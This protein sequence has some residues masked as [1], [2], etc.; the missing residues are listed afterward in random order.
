MLAQHEHW[1]WNTFSVQDGLVNS[2]GQCIV[3]DSLGFIWIGTDEG[4][5]RFDGTYFMNFKTVGGDST[6]LIDNRI[7]YLAVEPGGNVLIGTVSGFSM[8]NYNTG[9]FYSHGFDNS[10]KGEEWN[11]IIR[12][13]HCWPDGHIWIFTRCNVYDWDRADNTFSLLDKSFRST[14]NG[15]GPVTLPTDDP[16]KCWV[17]APNGLAMVDYK[18][19]SIAKIQP[20]GD[21]FEPS[22]TVAN[23][24][25]CTMDKY[26]KIWYNSISHGTFYCYDPKTNYQRSFVQD[27][28][29]RGSR[30]PLSTMV[31]Y[32]DRNDRLWV[33]TWSAEAYVLDTILNQRRHFQINRHLGNGALQIVR[34][35]YQAKNGDFWVTGNFG[36]AVHSEAMESV[37]TETLPKMQGAILPHDQLLH[38][39]LADST[40]GSFY[41]GSA[42][43]LFYYDDDVGQFSFY[44]YSNKD[45]HGAITEMIW[46]GQDILCAT[47][48]GLYLFLPKSGKFKKWKSGIELLDNSWITD[49]SVIGDDMFI[50]TRKAE[51]Y[52]YK[53]SS[54]QSVLYKHSEF[55]ANSPLPSYYVKILPD[56]H[57]N[58]WLASN[59]GFSC[60]DLEDDI[61]THFKPSQND[62]LK[63]AGNFW[64]MVCDDDGYIWFAAF[65]GVY[66]V[67]PITFHVDTIRNAN[68]EDN[69]V[70]YPFFVEGD[71]SIWFNSAV[72]FLICERGQTEMNQMRIIQPTNNL[73]AYSKGVVLG[74]K[75]KLFMSYYELFWYDHQKHQKGIIVNPPLVNWISCGDKT[76]INTSNVIHLNSGQNNFTFTYSSL[77][78]AAHFSLEYQYMVVGVDKNWISAIKPGTASYYNL[79]GGEYFVKVRVRTSDGDW[80]MIENPLKVVID[81]KY[82]ETF[83]FKI[84]IMLVSC[85]L[86]ALIYLWRRRT[87]WRVNQDHAVSSYIEK[88]GELGYDEMSKLLVITATKD[89]RYKNA[90]LYVS[91]G[92]DKYILK[93]KQIEKTIEVELPVSIDEYANSITE[94]IAQLLKNISSKKWE[95]LPIMLDDNAIAVVALEGHFGRS[96][97]KS[98]FRAIE[99]ISG[100]YAAVISNHHAE[101][102]VKRKEEM[103]AQVNT[104][105]AESQMVSLRAQ[106][107]PHF[108]FNCLNSIQQCIVMANY[109][110]ASTYLNKFS[111]L[112]RMVLNN[113]S[114]SLI[115]LEDEINV[116]TLYVELEHMRFQEKFDY[117]IE[118]SDDLD[119]E[120]VMIP[121]MLLQ[122]FVENALWHGLMHKE[123]ERQLNIRFYM[124]DEEVFVCEI[125]DNGI[126]RNKAREIKLQKTET[127]TNESKGIKISMDR[128][129]LIGIQQGK[130]ADVIFIDKQDEN[131][132]PLGTLVRFEISA[133][134]T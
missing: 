134:L 11:N 13:F 4:L 82:Y 125:D 77:S 5:S 39:L 16:F 37:R 2:E 129:H 79:A 17:A 121:S 56:L 73:F 133:F 18:T 78:S 22:S 86:L 67:D 35:F 69:Q 65:Y 7:R 104:L 112:F 107:N 54:Q 130:H 20:Q 122:P 40:S 27:T 108:I 53:L 41:V 100:I 111:R 95:V 63:F 75:V 64:N 28:L 114:R 46:F 60:L 81:L 110:E 99:K 89:L 132:Q 50:S 49:V 10:N 96:S 57:G 6:A 23:L 102:E 105:L 24:E 85:F 72:D 74:N 124:K 15:W 26:G 52:R 90:I 8:Y 118:F 92:S 97:S 14:L 48:E 70:V 19:K 126:G 51:L 30:V 61:F 45:Q 38:C 115:S 98:D 71:G 106:M 123:G 109:N 83:L 58:I 131:G 21:L 33:S 9:K 87:Q 29:E 103:L 32:A 34:T 3:E 91:D 84:C 44:R 76:M 66:R 93:S 12:G 47:Y 80:V 55:N 88:S 62:I 59:K 120:D 43:G 113:S 119:T 128:L 101:S 36:L 94:V 127:K 31:I 117:A 42:N 116:L 25:N 68:E 1:R